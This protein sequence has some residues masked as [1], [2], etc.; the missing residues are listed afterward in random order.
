MPLLPRSP[1]SFRDPDAV[2]LP[3]DGRMFRLVRESSALA[4]ARMLASP[5]VVAG[6]AAG[7]IARTWQVEPADHPVTL[8]ATGCVVYEHEALPFV[9][10]PCEWSPAMLARAGELTLEIAKQLLPHGF[11]LK[12]ATPANVLFRGVEPVFVDLPSIVERSPGSY[13]WLARHQFESTF[14]L[15]LAANALA[16]LPLSISLRDPV[17]GLEHGACARLLG[18]RRWLGL[19]RIADV[20]LP[21]L[22]ASRGEARGVGA[23]ANWLANDERALFTLQRSLETA[24]RRLNWWKQ[25]AVPAGSNWRGY[26][27]TRSHYEQEDVSRKRAFVQKVLETLVPQEVLDIGANTGEF[28]AMAAR[29]SRVVAL[30]SDEAAAAAMYDRANAEGLAIH[31]LVADFSRPTPP[32][33]WR[34]RETRS[35]L[36]R[37]AGRFD[38]VLMLAVVHHLRVSA[39]VPIRE[40]VDLIADITRS[41]LL[42]E[43]VPTEDP[44]FARIARGREGLYADCARPA[45]ECEFARLFELI[46][47]ERLG[48]GRTLYLMRRK[49]SADG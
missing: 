37:L 13:L 32:T 43:H 19:R 24:E 15:P 34:N 33:G 1:G 48:N 20:A 26:T 9:S 16:G 30:E 18:P 47:S 11:V 27:D 40:I 23:Q 22:L 44:M 3:R 36:D 10:Y 31:T 29:H 28:S 21:A 45:F 17:S 46:R 35:L 2:L 25:K 12:D 38:L 14:L 39:G 4:F 41:H 5:P 42:I 8:A 49:A 6:M 7:R